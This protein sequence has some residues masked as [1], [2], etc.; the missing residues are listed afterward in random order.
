MTAWFSE[1]SVFSFVKSSLGSKPSFLDRLLKKEER[2]RILYD[3]RSH[4]VYE[5]FFVSLNIL[6]VS[7]TYDN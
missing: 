4:C 3:R 6:L 1:H 2:I 7:Q 5:T